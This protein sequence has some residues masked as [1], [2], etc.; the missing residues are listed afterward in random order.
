MARI[1]ELIAMTVSFVV[2]LVNM[3][4]LECNYAIHSHLMFC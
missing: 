1:I 4:Q 2:S 3:A